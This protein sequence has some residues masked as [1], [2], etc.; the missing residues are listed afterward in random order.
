M[1][2]PKPGS[3]VM[4]KWKGGNKKEKRSKKRKTCS[5]YGKLKEFPTFGTRQTNNNSYS[6]SLEKCKLITGL[7]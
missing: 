7:K 1:A 4:N 5:E 2:Q 3:I 6:L